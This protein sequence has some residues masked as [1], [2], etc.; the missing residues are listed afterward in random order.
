MSP[1]E[2]TKMAHSQMP[3]TELLGLKIDSGEAGEV[4]ATT[5][6]RPEYCTVGGM[7]HGGYLMAVAD[8]VGALC[9][10]LNL[11]AGAT[12]STV[13]SKSNFFRPVTAGSI[14]FI[15][16][17]VHVG[18]TMIVVQT[19]AHGEEGKLVARTMQTQTVISPG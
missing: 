5:L 1:D 4:R 15:A 10:Y 18:R 17:P 19:D 3:F 9:A 12:T 6:W 7:I 11:P 8:S 13:E 14:D 2:L 16:T